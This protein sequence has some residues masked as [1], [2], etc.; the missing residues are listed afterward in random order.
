MKLIETEIIIQADIDKIWNILTDF[1]NYDKWNKFCPSIKTTG[2]IG[3]PLD[4]TV[5]L[6]K[7]KPTY[8]RE[9]MTENAPYEL[10]WGLNWGIFLKSHRLQR[11]EKMEDGQVRYYTYDK[12]WGLLTPLVAWLYESA[13]YQGFVLT[14]NCLKDFAEKGRTI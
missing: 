1:E 3:E 9:I 6:K 7:N 5:Y 13:I 12:L 8:Q 11:L 2:K 14:A 4:M 10:G